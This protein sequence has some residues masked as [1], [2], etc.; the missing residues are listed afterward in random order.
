MNGR[1]FLLLGDAVRFEVDKDS[2]KGKY[3]LTGS[4]TPNH[5]G[6]MHSGNAR[7]SK[8]R[9]NTMSL[10]ENRGFCWRG[11]PLKICSVIT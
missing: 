10:Y 7:I 6:I 1:R 2:R 8:V 5:K 4:A 9:M 3:I 11:R